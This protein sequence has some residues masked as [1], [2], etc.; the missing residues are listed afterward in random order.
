M[1]ILPAPLASDDACHDIEAGSVA[2]EESPLDIQ[3]PPLDI[4]GFR[5]AIEKAPIRIENVPL[6]FED[7]PFDIE[8]AWISNEKSSI[9]NEP[10][11]NT[12]GR[13]SDIEPVIPDREGKTADPQM[14]QINADWRTD[15]LR[16]IC[17]ICG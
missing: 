2:I 9:S 6:A 7:S 4:E 5:L 3:D 14:T 15:H 11:L 12:E 13:V 16:L 1:T 17:A 10:D 8:A